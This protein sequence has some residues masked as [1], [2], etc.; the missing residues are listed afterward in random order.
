MALRQITCPHCEK[1]VELDVT[2]VTRTRTCP[3]C[4][5]SILLELVSKQ[6]RSKRTAL[7]VP[8]V[9]PVEKLAQASH[10]ERTGP[11]PLEGDVFERMMHDPEVRQNQRRLI[12]GTGILLGVIVL[13][14]VLD[15]IEW[16]SQADSPNAASA[17]SVPDASDATPADSTSLIGPKSKSPR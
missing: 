14:C 3:N 9:D 5:Q 15:R 8:S 13:L 4:G 17:S 2:S 10:A 1:E 16:S 6:K 12:W 11:Q 7:M